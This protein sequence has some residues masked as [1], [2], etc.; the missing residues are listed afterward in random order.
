MTFLKLSLAGIGL[1]A[2]T[3]STASAYA[4]DIHIPADQ[5]T[6]QAGIDASVNG[7][8]VILDSAFYMGAGNRDIDFQGKAITVTSASGNPASCVIDCQ[9]AG[10]G[11]YFQSSEG[12]N[13]VVR[14]ITITNGIADSG[15]GIYVGFYC[16]PTI[17]HCNL[18]NN[19]ANYF[20]GGIFNDSFA[21]P[22][23]TNCTFI[24][25]GAFYAG[26]GMFNSGSSPSII[27]CSFTD[28]SAID[29]GGGA[30]YN[31]YSQPTITNS[32]LWGN[33][34]DDGAEIFNDNSTSIVTY[35]DVAGGYV[36]M[37]NINADPLFVN[38]PA[39]DLRLQA[40][41]L[42]IDAGN[43][44]AV[45]VATDILGNVR[46]SGTHVDMGAVET[47]NSLVIEQ[48]KLKRAGLNA[49]VKFVVR[50]TSTKAA[51]AAGLTSAM[52]GGVAA[53]Q[54]MPH[55]L[56]SIPAGGSVSVTL[57]FR[58][59]PGTKTLALAGVSS[60]GSFSFTQSVNVP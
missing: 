14:G 21:S 30:M 57:I 49:Q 55:A 20:G 48:L 11:F 2:L 54:T 26:G 42:A 22:S 23:I 12:A 41:S 51:S 1:A 17:T 31:T 44:S 4:A 56:G 13:S 5:P 19:S 16:A 9:S 40:G 10:R 35:S 37:G 39:G 36:G 29:F 28:N 7:D 45:S 3:L 27:N 25:N 59:S 53:N 46:L 58:V 8:M 15:G 34:A 6:I 47:Q 24:G 32:I 33:L 38:A 60:R 50:N 52:L 43:S 18:A